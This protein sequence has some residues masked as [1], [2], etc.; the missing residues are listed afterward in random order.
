MM[1]SHACKQTGAI[2]TATSFARPKSAITRAIRWLTREHQHPS[3]L[4]AICV[5]QSLNH[6]AGLRR[7]YTTCRVAGL[8]VCARHSHTEI[9]ELRI[10]RP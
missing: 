6:P 4:C 3:R 7:N 10:R 1:K 9:A 5:R 2:V 8:P